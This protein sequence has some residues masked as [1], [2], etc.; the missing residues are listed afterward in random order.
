MD[1]AEAQKRGDS[2]VCTTCKTRNPSDANFCYECGNVHFTQQ[3]HEEAN[4][5]E[6]IPLLQKLFSKRN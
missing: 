4:V 1:V 5:L 2:K 3:E 6:K